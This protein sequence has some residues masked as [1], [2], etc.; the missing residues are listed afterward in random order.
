LPSSKSNNK[1]KFIIEF[2]SPVDQ[3]NIPRGELCI[4]RPKSLRLFYE[5][6][7]KGL[8]GCMLSIVLLAI[9]IFLG[10]TL[11]PIY[12]NNLNFESDLKT[13]VSR[14]G[15]R[16]FDNEVVIKDIIDLARRN[17]IR[18]KRE[19]VKVERYAGQVHIRVNYSV[20]VDLLLTDRDLNF[21]VKVSSFT[22][23][24]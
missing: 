20:P 1:R 10:I 14:A 16:F 8:I 3:D 15:A 12:Y 5:S 9:I 2:S 19:N 4:M 7:G 6:D 21:E 23:A 24:L 18:L 13:E 11:G 17:E 22:G